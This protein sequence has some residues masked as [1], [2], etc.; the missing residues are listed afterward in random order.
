MSFLLHC[1]RRRAGAAPPL[2]TLRFQAGLKSN[3]DV[4]LIAIGEAAA[5]L[6]LRPSALR[7]YDERG[8]VSPRSRLAG[9]RMYGP[10]ELRQL[11][12][13]K[14]AHRLGIPLGT[15]AAVLGEPSP[16]WRRA[17]RDQI[18]ELDQLIAQA[19]SAQLFLR[20][21]LNCPADHPVRD[22]PTMTAA[23]DRL[24]A[25]MTFD[26]VAA[27]HAVVPPKATAPGP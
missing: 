15:A 4:D 8:L 14:I 25:G 12:F 18:T 1:S 2:P 24:A 22:C 9:R 3:G 7:Y 11:A 10:G 5:R 13:L 6:G 20:H 21:A 26:Q 16:Q 19:Q 17:V 27:E 23:L